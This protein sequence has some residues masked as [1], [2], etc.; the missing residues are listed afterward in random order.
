[1]KIL[2]LV[3]I[4]L[5][6][7]VSL[8]GSAQDYTFRV[9]VN[10]GKNEVKAGENWQLIKVGSNLKSADEVKVSENAYIGLA[11]VS[12]KTLE[13]KQP[14]KY[15]VADLAARVSGNTSVLN[16]YTDFVLSANKERKNNLAATGA[17][18]RGSEFLV[19]IPIPTKNPV[20]YNDVITISWDNKVAGPYVVKF[21]SMFDDELATIETAENNLTI[22]LSD[23]KFANEDNIIVVVSSK[24]EPKKSDP[25]T[26]KRLSKADKERIK[27]E[28]AGQ[29]QEQTAIA[30]LMLAAFYEKNGLLIDAGTAYQDAIKLEP[31]VADFKQS[32]EEFLIGNGLKKPADQKK[33]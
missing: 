10:K 7:V 2:K 6:A 4:G 9:L 15:K 12:G 19:F 16:K 14:G 22:D 23:A 8:E 24:S 3:L 26:L 21:N 17:V 20:V 28:L 13:L 5:L 29:T 31:N 1:M 32:Y 33:K 18:T 30:K 25:Y 11:H 27:N